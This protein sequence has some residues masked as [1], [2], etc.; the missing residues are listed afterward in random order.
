[1]TTTIENN[2]SEATNKAP[3]DG[4]AL[5]PAQAQAPQVIGRQLVIE[6]GEGSYIVTREGQRL[7]D[8]TAGL[9]HAKSAT[10]APSWPRRPT[11]R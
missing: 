8:G 2:A 3:V 11:T 4:P 9:W 5:W 7:F 1:M 10:P 6:G